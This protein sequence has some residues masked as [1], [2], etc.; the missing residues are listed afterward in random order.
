M[1]LMPFTDQE[2]DE[3]NAFMAKQQLDRPLCCHQPMNRVNDHWVCGQ[4]SMPFSFTK[5]MTKPWRPTVP[6]PL[7]QLDEELQRQGEP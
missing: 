2:R 3:M 5:L 6:H 1:G 7:L 4:C